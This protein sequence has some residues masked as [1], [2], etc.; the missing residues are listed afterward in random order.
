[1]CRRRQPIEQERSGEPGVRPARG[2]QGLVGARG[3]IDR[4]RS[5]VVP[6]GLSFK[7]PSHSVHLKL[8]SEFAL[9]APVHRR[10][11]KSRA[12]SSVAPVFTRQP[13]ALLSCCFPN[14]RRLYL[15]TPE[16][17]NTCPEPSSL[18]PSSSSARKLD[19]S[20]W[21]PTAFCRPRWAR[22]SSSST[23]STPPRRAETSASCARAATTRVR[24]LLLP[25][26]QCAAASA[27][28]DRPCR[29]H[30]PPHHR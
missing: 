16:P 9:Q 26:R 2:A 29:H 14:T 27:E 25:P 21:L 30:L 6:F 11:S 20:P 24:L 18:H 19:K 13:R 17:V 4:G 12:P 15:D 1:M 8:P 22:S 7:H 10:P 28:R 3:G 23:T 5:H